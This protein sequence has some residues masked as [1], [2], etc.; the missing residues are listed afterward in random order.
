MRKD[1]IR[2]KINNIKNLKFIKS[3][4]KINKVHIT[5]AVSVLV[6]LALL[7]LFI[8]ALSQGFLGGKHIREEPKIPSV[9]IGCDRVVW[10]GTEL[11]IIA[12]IQN[13]NKPLFNWTVDGN[14]AGQGQNIMKKFDKGEHRV[15]LN[16]TFDNKNLTANQ[17]TLVIDSTDGVSVRD[18]SASNNQWGFQTMYKGKKYGV[19]GVRVS[20][21]SSVQSEV[22]ACGYLSSK[23]LM[24][25]NYTWNAIYQGNTIG[26]GKFN[27]KEVNEV[28]ITRLD[29]AK[30]Y[31]A[32]STVNAQIVVVNTGS[33]AVTGFEIKTL[34]VNNNYAF[35]GD[36]A[37]KEYI[38]RYNT[39]L[40][41]GVSYDIPIGFTIPEKVSGI[42]PSGKYTITVS[43]VLN[44][45][46]VDK[47]VV[48]TEVK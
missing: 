1:K 19:K 16:V 33:T 17:T 11:E 47:K 43:L 36:K 35:M 32:G 15:I 2:E 9:S 44:G 6:A 46:V 38:D 25:G 31:T 22:N 7:L 41:P 23:A 39:D 10:N 8:F 45:K 28:R 5:V 13:I 48:N 29:I 27:I 12:T 30:S 20:V 40:K 18:S 21:D 34:A 42:R 14:D 4:I 26:S 3:R 37:K 24:A